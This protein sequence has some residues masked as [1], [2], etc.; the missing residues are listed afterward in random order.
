MR[1]FTDYKLTD[2]LAWGLIKRICTNN[3]YLATIIFIG[4]MVNMELITNLSNILT[5]L[6]VIVTIIGSGKGLMKGNYFISITSLLIGSVIVA[7]INAPT[8]FNA[9]GSLIIGILKSL[10]GAING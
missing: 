3:A 8:E 6:V 7:L 5:F 4:G 10:G 1:I 2:M 9:L